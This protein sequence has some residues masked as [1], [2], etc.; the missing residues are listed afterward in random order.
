MGIAFQSCVGSM[1]QA[2]ASL[3]L[4][5]QPLNF[6]LFFPCKRDIGVYK[7]GADLSALSGSENKGG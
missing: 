3:T 4:T 1:R 5:P 7:I 2:E 6:M